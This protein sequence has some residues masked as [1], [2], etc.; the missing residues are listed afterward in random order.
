MFAVD[1][2]R[3]NGVAQRNITVKNIVAHRNLVV[4]GKNSLATITVEEISHHFYRGLVFAY[5]TWKYEGIGRGD[6]G[7]MQD[8]NCTASAL[9]DEHDRGTVID[10]RDNTTY[11]IA[12]LKDD[13]CWM[14]DNLKL[15][16]TTVLTSSDTDNPASG[17]KLTI[18]DSNYNANNNYDADAAY[19][20]A[21]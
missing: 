7:S 9:V 11:R 14:I 17:F 16:T 2:A 3:D 12:K 20:D 1:S 6:F 8:F 4:R 5:A 21:T 19:I 10:T 13:R 15:E 18:T